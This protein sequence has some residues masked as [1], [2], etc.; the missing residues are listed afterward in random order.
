MRLNREKL[1]TATACKDMKQKTLCEITGISRATISGIYCGRSCSDKTAAA[2]A[3]ALG[4]KLA[5]LTESR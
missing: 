1:I 5:D 3:E 4:M 2:I